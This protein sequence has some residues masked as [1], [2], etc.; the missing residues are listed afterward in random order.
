MKEIKHWLLPIEMYK[1]GIKITNN[2]FYF[3]SVFF[4]LLCS[5]E[6]E[7]KLNLGGSYLNY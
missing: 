3:Y 2:Y 5:W 6:S 7:P 1:A 4:E